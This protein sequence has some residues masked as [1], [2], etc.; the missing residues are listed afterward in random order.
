MQNTSDAVL[1]P[2]A[3]VATTGMHEIEGR[4]RA[5]SIDSVLSAQRALHHDIA[6]AD[7]HPQWQPD[8]EVSNCP[9]CF[10]KFGFFNRKHHCRKCGLIY[11]ANCSSQYISY[12]PL[13]Y[14]VFPPSEGGGFVIRG[15]LAHARFRT[16]GDCFDEIKMIKDAMGI[17][18]DSEDN[19]SEMESTEDDGEL[20]REELSTHVSS[21]PSVGKR[22]PN[23]ITMEVSDSIMIDSGGNSNIN[24]GNSGSQA[25]ATDHDDEQDECPICAANLKH[26]S[27]TNKEQ[28][29]DLC[30]RQQEFGSPVE[31][32]TLKRERNRMLVSHLPND[33][34]PIVVN[35]DNEC[36]ICLEEF[37]PGDKVGRLECLCC[38]H[39]K[40]IKDWITKKG[41]VECPVHALHN[42]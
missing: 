14:V 6:N 29:I 35:D 4:N 5:P 7:Q 39:Y 31:N 13:S 38:F 20:P 1:E 28:H 36:V 11:C 40:C 18:N 19:E 42:I 2:R 22:T 41:F 12:L 9:K 3:A 27:E 16:C 17:P 8:I 33:G 32:S 15:R 37:L 23:E 30:I 21:A 34:L 26:M 25:A 10:K 24:N